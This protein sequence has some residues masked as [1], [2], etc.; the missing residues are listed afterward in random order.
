M[1]N[2][3]R[4]YKCG[5][6]YKYISLPVLTSSNATY[7]VKDNKNKLKNN[8][9]RAKTTIRD[10]ILCNDFVYFVTL[11]INSKYNRFD[12]TS[13]RK[14]VNHRIRNYRSLYGLNLKFLFVPEKHKN[15]AWHLHGV[16]NIGFEPTIYTNMF[17]YLSCKIF[18]TL[19]YNNVSNIQDKSRVS[20]YILKYITKDLDQREKFNHTFFASHGLNKP[21]LI[22]SV[23]YNN[24]YFD[25]QFFDV[26]TDFCYVKYSDKYY[27]FTNGILQN[28]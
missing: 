5:D 2:N 12:L 14:L 24:S 11:T 27:G 22:S 25:Y 19:G 17:G 26:K 28:C 3:L 15:G 6:T 16:L 21:K 8:I 1:L 7:Y 18:D 20:S 13:I 10:T 23:F 9:I 4:V